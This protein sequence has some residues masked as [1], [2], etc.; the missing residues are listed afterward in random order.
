VRV[1]HW[2]LVAAF[3]GAFALERPRELHETLGFIALAAVTIRVVWGFVGPAHA[4]FADFVPRPASFV[5]YLRDVARGSERRYLGH[6]PAGG[7]MVVALLAMVA[8]LGTTGWMMVLD[9]FR[10]AEWLEELHEGAANA[11]L[12]LV[13]LHVLGVFWESARHGEN[14]VAAMFTGLKHR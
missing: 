6:N 13:V 14:L 5:G 4:R 7:A 12:A 1:F 9:G 2:T 10:G 8:L 11:A 3:F